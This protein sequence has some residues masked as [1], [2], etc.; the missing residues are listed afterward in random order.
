MASPCASAASPSWS[1]STFARPRRWRRNDLSAAL[2]PFLALWGLTF[3]GAPPPPGG[4]EPY[5]GAGEV[6]FV[7]RGAESLVLKLLAEGSDEWRSGDV[8][9]HWDGRGAVRLVERAPGAVLIERA[10]P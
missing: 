6:A 7:R 3:E 9:A 10:A 8:L 5:P 1:A 4:R 2:D